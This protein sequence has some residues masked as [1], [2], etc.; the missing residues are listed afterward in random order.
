MREGSAAQAL[1]VTSALPMAAGLIAL[2]QLSP[3]ENEKKIDCLLFSFK[4][5]VYAL[6]TFSDASPRA[7]EAGFSK[8]CSRD[9]HG[10]ESCHVLRATQAFG[11]E[12]VVLRDHDADLFLKLLLKGSGRRAYSAPLEAQATEDLSLV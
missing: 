3:G 9:F 10:T 8:Q 6:T 12:M 7:V 4:M 5:V 11:I 2:C 1:A